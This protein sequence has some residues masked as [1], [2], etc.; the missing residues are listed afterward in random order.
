[1]VTSVEKLKNGWKVIAEDLISKTFNTE[2]FDVIMVCNGHLSSSFTPDVP[3]M[4]EFVGVQLHSHDYRVPEKFQSM[5][6]LIIGSGPSGIDICLDVAKFANQV[7]VLRIYFIS[8]SIPIF[9]N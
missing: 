1:M 3:G 2:Y 5:N 6:V 7:N 8:Y 9:S 4:H